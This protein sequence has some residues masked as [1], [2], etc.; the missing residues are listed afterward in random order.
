MLQFFGVNDNVW[1]VIWFCIETQDC[2]FSYSNVREQPLM[3]CE[4]FLFQ[5]FKMQART[6]FGGIAPDSYY[7]C[8]GIN[9]VSIRINFLHKTT[10][11]QYL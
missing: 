8:N 10:A 2:F 5:A 4:V 6:T 7:E 1:F 3:F 11:F 9:I